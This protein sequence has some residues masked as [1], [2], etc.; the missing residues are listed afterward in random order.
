MREDSEPLG[1]SSIFFYTPTTQAMKGLLY[2]ICLGH[3]YCDQYYHINRSSYDSFLIIIVGRGRGYTTMNGRSRKAEQ[4]DIVI[5]DCYEPHIYGTNDEWEIYWMHFD[6]IS[7]RSYYE[8]ICEQY[9]QI[10][11]LKPNVREEVLKRLRWIIDSFEQK[12]ISREVQISKYITDM[13]TTILM[14]GEEKAVERIEQSPVEAAIDYIGKN[15]D[16]PITVGSLANYAALSTYHFTRE[17]KKKTG[18]APHQYITAVRLN[19]ARFYLRT[20]R[21]SIK[22]IG[23]LCGFQSEN[24]FCITFKKETGLTP[25]QFRNY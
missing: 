7:A 11:Q 25:T 5:L 15:Y 18:S 23:G 22:E 17:F 9:G 20:T 2:P 6:G 12:V 13:L 10:F 14:A 21:K 4:G 8:M 19:T 24:S 3:F 1:G 16:K